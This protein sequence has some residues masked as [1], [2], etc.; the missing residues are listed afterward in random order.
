MTRMQA[1][2]AIVVT[3]VAIG[4]VVGIVMGRRGYHSPTWILV[5]AVFGPLT[6]PLT[7]HA[8]RD[9]RRWSRPRT[10]FAGSVGTGT[11]DVLVG[12]HGSA[13]SEA[14]FATPSD[15]W[16]TGSAASPWQASW[17]T[18]AW[19]QPRRGTTGPGPWRTWSA[20]E[21]PRMT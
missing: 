18:T 21:M 6:I 9:A 20:C 14:R 12:I 3:W 16:A 8:V 13:G 19:V 1:V 2:I 15:S 5:G 17:T 4:V 7:T 11:V 10:L